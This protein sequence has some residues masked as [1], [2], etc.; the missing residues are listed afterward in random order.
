MTESSASAAA[1]PSPQGDTSENMKCP[2]FSPPTEQPRASISRITSLS[3][4]PLL[5]TDTPLFASD[6]S[7][8]MLLW[9][10]VTIAFEASAPRSFAS[11]A[12]SPRISSPSKIEPV[13]SETTTL[14]PSPS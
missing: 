6:S 3:P 4:I 2:E 13:S 14:S 11:R 9:R 10:V 5:K 1:S 7:S 12:I 8:P